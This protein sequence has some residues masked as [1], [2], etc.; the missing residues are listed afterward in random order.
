MQDSHGLTSPQIQLNLYDSE[1]A[2]A[3]VYGVV[4]DTAVAG[5]GFAETK[6]A[7]ALPSDDSS[8]RLPSVDGTTT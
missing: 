2:F 4:L 6:R 7:D 1:L 3:G 8:N 5:I